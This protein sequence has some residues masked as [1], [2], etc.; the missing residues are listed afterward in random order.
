[1]GLASD[2]LG[3]GGQSGLG[4]KQTLL[5]I[6]GA[7]G[8]LAG[9]LTALP[10]TQRYLRTWTAP[11]ALSVSHPP[12]LLIAVWFGFLAG[13]AE[14]ARLAID[15]YLSGRIIGQGIDVIWMAPAVS[16]GLFVLGGIAF[17][18]ISRRVTRLASLRPA[19]FVFALILYYGVML[20]F[21]RVHTLASV[22]LAAGL[23]KLTADLVGHRPILLFLPMHITLG[24]L[25]VL[26]THRSAWQ[27]EQQAGMPQPSAAMTRRDF[28]IGTGVYLGGLLIAA[29][30]ADQYAEYRRGLNLG[31]ARPS[32]ANVLLI[33]LDTVRAQSLSLYGYHRRTTPNLERLAQRGILFTRAFAAAPWTLPS[34]ASLFTG[35]FPHELSVGL[36]RPLDGT[37]PTVAEVLTQA[38]YNSGGFVANRFYCTSEF[39]LG[40]G[41]V[42]YEDYQVSVAQALDATTLSRVMAKSI[43]HAAGNHDLLGRKSAAEITASFLDWLAKQDSSRPFFAFLNYFDAH[44]PYLP[45][46]EFALRF[47]PKRPRGHFRDSDY[48]TLTVQDIEELN[49]A[50]DASIAF[51]DDQLGRLFDGLA[52]LSDLTNTMVV[53]TADHGEHFGEHGLLDHGSSLYAQQLHVPL[54]IIP[55][56]GAQAH[57]SIPD[58]VSLQALAATIMDVVT[59]N[60]TSVFPGGSLSRYW[61]DKPRHQASPGDP[62]LSEVDR[63][64]HFPAWYPVMKGPMK[65][66]VAGRSHYIRNLGDGSEELYD[67]QADPQEKDDLSRTA[68]GQVTVRELRSLMDARIKAANG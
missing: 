7:S 55:P 33:V 22:V 64:V 24:W 36:A 10:A 68:S 50:Y 45:P 4:V 63:G 16:V 11:P 65:S 42:H 60:Q 1:L 8:L 59:P 6:A 37:Y 48:E 15:R 13:L 53:V 41:F 34:H 9:W 25:G 30:G 20:R 58:P 12:V 28:L 19:V 57:R 56:A 23:A 46:L 5:L 67:L 43:R 32:A 18:L 14:L 39:G 49:L 62:L 17:T 3:V 2:V 44:A 26:S 27:A 21:G 54:L 40:R 51:V 29:R 61:S 52:Q 47:S 66:L 38:G 35:R 31:P